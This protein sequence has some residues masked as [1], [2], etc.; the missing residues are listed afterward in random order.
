MIQLVSGVGK[1]SGEL[2]ASRH[3]R[4]EAKILVLDEYV[5]EYEETYLSS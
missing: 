4:I 2:V 3:L 5:T 1:K